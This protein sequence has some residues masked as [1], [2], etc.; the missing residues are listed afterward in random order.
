MNGSK[1][2]IF[3]IAT[4]DLSVVEA[5]WFTRL[6]G[7]LGYCFPLSTETKEMVPNSTH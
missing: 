1:K 2:S 7:L 5:I 3:G 4:I 6:I